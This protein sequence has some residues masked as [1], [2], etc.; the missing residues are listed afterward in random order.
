LIAE[1]RSQV[2]SCACL[3]QQQSSEPQQR[4]TQLSLK[5]TLVKELVDDLT[6]PIDNNDCEQLMKRVAMGRKNWLFRDR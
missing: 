1:L 5:R 2:A 4:Q 3:L 6:I